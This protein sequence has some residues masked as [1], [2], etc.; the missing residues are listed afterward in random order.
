MIELILKFY[1]KLTMD[2]GLLDR[3][4]LDMGVTDVYYPEEEI[5]AAFNYALGLYENASQSRQ[6]RYL[7][8]DEMKI[9]TKEGYGLLMSLQ[10]AGIVGP[11]FVDMLMTRAVIM[12]S[13]PLDEPEITALAEYYLLN[14]DNIDTPLSVDMLF[15][16][17][18]SAE[19]IN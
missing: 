6:I 11:S 9:F 10:M 5:A 3:G 18:P 19:E 2:P 14:P 13:I 16:M 12:Q 4:R 7:S 17:P 8:P 1:E 15:F